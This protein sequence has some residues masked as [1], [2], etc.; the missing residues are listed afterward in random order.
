MQGKLTAI[1]CALYALALLS[2]LVPA[3]IEVCGAMM[4]ERGSRATL[5]VLLSV[6][7]ALCAFPSSAEKGG[8]PTNT[9]PAV[10]GGT[11]SGNIY[12]YFE[13]P[14]ARLWPIGPEIRRV[15]P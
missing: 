8:G 9:P 5:F 12:L 10:T 14:G 6:A 4:R 15:D 2:W 13:S 3:I 7:G 1:V 11:P